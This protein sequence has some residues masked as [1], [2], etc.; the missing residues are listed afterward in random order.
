MKIIEF[1][2]KSSPTRE[3]AK[4]WLIANV[5]QFPEIIPGRIGK[6]LFHGWRFIQVD[7]NNVYF[8]NC[9]DQGISKE[10]FYDGMVRVHASLLQ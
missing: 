10:E 2:L 3:Q 6:P 9:I 8:A 7:N 1:R 5:S 4:N